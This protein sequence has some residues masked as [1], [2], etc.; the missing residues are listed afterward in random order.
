MSNLIRTGVVRY[1][2]DTGKLQ[3]AQVTGK[4]GDVADDVEMFQSYGF[5]SNPKPADGNGQGSEVVLL[6]NN[7]YSSR[8]IGL[9]HDDRR[10]RPRVSAPGDVAV[11]SW[12]DDPQAGHQS[13]KHRIALDTAGGTRKIII[14]ASNGVDTEITLSDAGQ[15]V[16][17]V[18]G[19]TVTVTEAAIAVEAPTVTVQG[20][21]VSVTG[22]NVAVTGTHCS[23]TGAVGITGVLT[24]THG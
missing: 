13:A 16:V 21:T 23:V 3:T 20:Q 7:G 4:S 8:L 18:G 22:E 24:V 12:L 10:Y 6:A 15:V 9:C 19:S 14:R 17:K 11:Y 1:V 5:T 2:K